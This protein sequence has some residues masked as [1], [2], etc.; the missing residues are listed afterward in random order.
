MKISL[1]LG[2]GGSK[3][4]SHLGVLRCLERQGIKV[5]AVAG[6]SAGGIVAALYAA[7][8]SPDVILERFKQLDF[9]RMYG[10][11]PGDGPSLLGVAGVNRVVK[12]MLD[13]RTF[14]DLPIPAA[15]VSVDLRSG[16]EIVL[17]QGRVADA[18][19]ATMALPGIFPPVE[20]ERYL[21]I[22]GGVMDPVPVAPARALAPLLPVVAVVLNT[23]PEEPIELLAPPRIFR[24]VPLLGTIAHLRLAQAFN[25]FVHSLELGSSYIT[26][27]RLQI[28]KPDLVIRPQVTDVGLLDRVDVDEIVERGEKA[29]EAIVPELRRVFRWRRRLLRYWDYRR[30]A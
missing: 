2:G 10:H 20:L 29:T 8:Y 7:G 4:I 25:I 22:D 18:V 5:G 19:L 16:K 13:E 21:L 28:D 1:A 3:G 12:E 15:L 17:K 6:T 11:E 26:E 14:A 30:A 23:L 24:N 9:S 27:L